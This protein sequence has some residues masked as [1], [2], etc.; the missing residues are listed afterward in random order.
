MKK[1]VIF[2]ILNF[3]ALALGGLATGTGVSS[4]WYWN[5]NQA[6]WTPPGWVFGAA[7]TTIMICY[8]FY[9]WQLD[10]ISENKK[11]IRL[12]FGLQWLLNVI[13]NPIFF[14]L[15]QV[16]LGLIVIISLAV[17]VAIFFFRY[18]KVLKLKSLLIF[19][20]LI[21]LV[22]ATSLNMYIALMN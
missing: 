7:W 19:P 12:M 2:F 17:V 11:E 18:W 8:S 3:G 5:L 16:E 22:I 21:W 15:H 14:S 13:W 6:P 20:Y 1:L 4:D 10:N 9:M